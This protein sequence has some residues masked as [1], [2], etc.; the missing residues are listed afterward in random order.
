MFVIPPSALEI[1]FS[2]S[3]VL[4]LATGI[5]LMLAGAHALRNS[6][7]ASP[8]VAKPKLKVS[9]LVVDPN[10]QVAREQL[11]TATRHLEI[12][13]RMT[14][15]G[16]WEY[17]YK[18]DTLWWSEEAYR[19][20]GLNPAT[21]EPL[22]AVFRQLIHPMDRELVNSANIAALSEGR[23]FDVIHRIVRPD[24]EERTIHARAEI[25]RDDNDQGAAMIGTMQDVT[26]Q[27]KVE[28]ALRRAKSQAESASLAKTEFLANIS[29]ELRTPLNSIIGFT[30]I[31]RDE[32]FGPIEQSKYLE[33]AADV[34]ESGHH[35]LSLI[36]DV[37]DVSI[38][39]S[40][41]LSLD[42]APVDVEGLVDSCRRIVTD[43]AVKANVRLIF[44]V[45]TPIPMLQVDQRRIKQILLNL[46]SN[47]IKFT[48][49]GGSVSL[50][51]WIDDDQ[52]AVFQVVDTGIGIAEQDLET[53]LSPFG[54]VDDGLP[55]HHEG[56]G[57]GLPLSK[58]LAEAHGGSLKIESALE[59]GTRVTLRLPADRTLNVE[60]LSQRPATVS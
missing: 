3:A 34:H 26:E 51:A 55:R 24:G 40:G 36:N 49:D 19:I 44:D 20:F 7:R 22:S 42:E 23:P 52:G 29:H 2:T 13:Q 9:E 54:Q 27:K 11:D 45:Q 57:L 46:L 53:V 16:N 25:L 17:R 18:T 48:P 41:N 47:A 4:F 37:L 8:K 32:I 31:M 33:Y 6:N 28:A 1:F 50:E 14:H 12:S 5:A 10:L 58:N 60:R 56:V 43:R 39:E 21:A 30:E 59:I 15:V 38:I 35:L